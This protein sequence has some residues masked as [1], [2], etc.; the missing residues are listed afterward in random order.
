[1]R[2]VPDFARI[3]RQQQF[4][5]AVIN[6]MLQ[7]AEIA[8]APSL[9]GPILSHLV[10]DN[11]ARP[12]AARLPCRPD[13][14]RVDGRSGV[15]RSS[16]HRW[17]GGRS[18]G[19]AHGSG[20]DQDLR[21][22]PAGQT[23]RHL[24][25]TL[26]GQPISEANIVVPVVDHGS[27]GN[28]GQVEKVLSD[29]GFDVAP[30]D[31]RLRVVRLDGQG[32]GDRVHRA[33]TSGRPVVQQY[34]PDLRVVEVKEGALRSGGCVRD[35]RLRASSLWA[36]DAPRRRTASQRADASPGPVG[37]GGLAAP[38]AHVHQREAADPGRWH[39]DP[40]PRPRI[41]PRSRHQRGGRRGRRR[42]PTR[43]ERRSATDRTG[44]ST[45]PT[46]TRRRRS[47]WLTPS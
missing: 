28:A 21:G 37:R 10:D 1:M 2:P 40:V 29:G 6:R 41:D 47:V 19:G 9:V 32:V 33:T 8:Q 7:P 18:V 44:G 16:G 11:K 38:P 27:G 36:S 30:G 17:L 20:R 5:R 25:A 12:H 31:H 15:P 43:S 4:L 23:A 26:P 13:E 42:R 39:P 24:G 45:S 14:R 3:G 22:D 46:S 34:F 35:D